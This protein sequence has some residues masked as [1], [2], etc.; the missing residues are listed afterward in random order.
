MAGRGIIPNGLSGE[1]PGKTSD[2]LFNVPSDPKP[3]EVAA[4]QVADYPS[5]GG[6]RVERL[7]MSGEARGYPIVSAAAPSA[8][9][10][11]FPG[12]NR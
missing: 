2:P 12:S 7:G 4:G 10:S 3:M 5:A 11:F 6:T 1:M 8:C 9:P